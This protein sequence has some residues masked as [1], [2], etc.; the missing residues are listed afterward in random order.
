MKSKQIIVFNLLLLIF[1]QCVWSKQENKDSLKIIYPLAEEYFATVGEHSFVLNSN[2]DDPFIMHTLRVA[3]GGAKSLSPDVK[4]LIDIPD[5]VLDTLFLESSMTYLQG[6]IKYKHKINDWSAF[7]VAFYGIGRVGTSVPTLIYKGVSGIT[8]FQLA[9]Y[10][11]LFETKKSIFTTSLAMNSDSYLY[12]NIKDFIK[13]LLDSTVKSPALD[14]TKKSLST[15]MGISYAYGFTRF[16]GLMITAHGG[17]GE[18]PSNNFENGLFWDASIYFDF[19]FI[20]MNVPLGF[21]LGTKLNTF[22]YQVDDPVNYSRSAF[23]KLAYVGQTDF[24]VGLEANY[25]YIPNS[26]EIISSTNILQTQFVI[27]LYF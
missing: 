19:N 12:L 4:F 8:G 15:V 16:F 27:E 7:S 21:N 25:F 22:P 20:P 1:S 5:I 18:L 10:F 11:K 23:L 24:N 9:W 26:G 3:L 14:K 17:Y 6:S 13:D 2:T